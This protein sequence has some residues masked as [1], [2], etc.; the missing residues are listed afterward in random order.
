MNL[1]LNIG[2][3][4]ELNEYRPKQEW[5]KMPDISRHMCVY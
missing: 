1:F 4:I 5:I 3:Q 2:Y